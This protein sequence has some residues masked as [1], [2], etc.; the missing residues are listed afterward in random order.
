MKFR[1]L[2]T[3][4][5][6]TVFLC[7]LFFP[8]VNK[9]LLFIADI[10]N[11]ENRKKAT[12][13]LLASTPLDSFPHR[14]EKYYNDTF[15]L[16]SRALRQYN[17]F[18]YFF[19]DI[20]PNSYYVIIGKDDWLFLP[21]EEFDGYSG[22]IN[23]TRD[24]LASVKEELEYRQNY[25]KERGCKFY[26][27]I[28]PSKACIYPE[29]V[30][31]KQRANQAS[32]GEKLLTYL[33]KNSSV[34]TV[35][36]YQALR[37]NKKYYRVYYATDN[38]WTRPGA[39]IGANQFLQQ[40]HNDYEQVEPMKLSDFDISSIDTFDGNTSSIIGIPEYF[41]DINYRLSPKK[42]LSH[43]A[44]KAGYVADKSFPY[45]FMYEEVRKIEGTNK[46]RL[47]I[48]SD[49]FGNFLFPLL[50]ENFSK[51][52][53]VWDNWKYELHEDIVEKEKPNIVLL[54]IHEKNIRSLLKENSKN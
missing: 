36:L 43:P 50:S 46:P 42:A 8:L 39:F 53:K 3:A 18:K 54:L 32:I 22:K 47:L 6:N 33:E 4:I 44:E 2:R 20:P 15:P 34:N 38:H 26:L 45:P 5:I 12:Q 41:P 14:Y 49:S 21:G 51:T 27:M 13:P 9:N 35:N 17:Y 52:V 31:E 30:S 25:L 40:V 23:F 37:E 19:L 10:K 29:R 16:R 24:E 11:F 1:R 48:I 28:A 7:L